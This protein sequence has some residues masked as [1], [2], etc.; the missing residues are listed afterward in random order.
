MDEKKPASQNEPLPDELTGPRAAERGGHDDLVEGRGL[1]D[2]ERDEVVG[3]YSEP[4]DEEA[5][6]DQAEEAG[7]GDELNAAARRAA[8]PDRPAPRPAPARKRSAGVR[9]GVRTREIPAPRPDKRGEGAGF[10][11]GSS[12]AREI[13]WV[14][15]KVR[16]RL[17]E[18]YAERARAHVRRRPL[19]H[20]AGAFA[21]GFIAARLFRR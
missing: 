15:Q 5:L 10:A 21:L 18:G 11:A 7:A 20:I 3:G 14:A 1:T 13:V 6:E 4:V 16:L 12:G 2:R 8:G 9:P 19:A 17:K